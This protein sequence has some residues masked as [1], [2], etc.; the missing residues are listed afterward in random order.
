MISSN[1]A[2]LPRVGRRRERLAVAR[3]RASR[4][5][6]PGPARGPSL[7]AEA[8]GG[9]P[10]QDERA[11][12]EARRPGRRGSGSRST[13]SCTRA[14]RPP[15]LRAGSRPSRRRSMTPVSRK[16]ANRIPE[17]KMGRLRSATAAS[18]PA[19]VGAKPPARET[20]HPRPR[21]GQQQHE[22]QHDAAQA[23]PAHR[24]RGQEGHGQDARDRDPDHVPGVAEGEARAP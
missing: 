2:D 12:I 13:W 6:G 19:A 1:T 14:G 8:R 11:G 16:R 22:R 3:P 5:P 24:H 23:P 20:H 7:R 18:L 21:L 10:G 4:H 15:S 17:K 9:P